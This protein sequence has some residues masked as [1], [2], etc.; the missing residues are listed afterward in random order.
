MLLGI[1]NSEYFVFLN[2]G[3]HTVLSVEL[4]LLIK[5]RISLHP[6]HYLVMDVVETSSGRPVVNV[7]RVLG[8]L[9]KADRNV[10]TGL[11]FSCVI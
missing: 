6:S 9:L 5:A 2:L 7:L 1:Q 8:M 3:Q 11:R 4:F 10:L